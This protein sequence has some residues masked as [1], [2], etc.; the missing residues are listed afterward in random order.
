[1]VR[2]VNDHRFVWKSK[3]FSIGVSVGLVEVTAES[4]SIEDLLHAADSAC[5]VAKQQ[6]RGRVHVYSARDEVS[7][8]QRGDIHWLR[9]LQATT[10][11]WRD[12]L[13]R[14]DIEALLYRLAAQA[15]FSAPQFS[16][17]VVDEAHCISH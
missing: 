14:D 3:I 4:T 16:L 11:L 10:P 15:D 8:R 9:Q 13:V 1:M 6:G 17:V 12:D 5:Y 7:A 2:A